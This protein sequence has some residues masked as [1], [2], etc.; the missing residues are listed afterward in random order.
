M[1]RRF[2]K[3][4]N[5]KKVNILTED[6]QNN[7]RVITELLGLSKQE[8]MNKKKQAELEQA[9]REI[10]N[11]DF[12]NVFINIPESK[13]YQDM[14]KLTDENLKKITNDLPTVASLV[15]ELFDVNLT[16]IGMIY[17]YS[18]D[19]NLNPGI[20][21]STWLHALKDEHSTSDKTIMDSNKDCIT[22]FK[23]LIEKRATKDS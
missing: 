13:S 12:S 15:P 3:I 9:Y 7:D 18:P 6:R 1:M 16:K 11:F 22:K 21:P 23:K 17:K 8:K 19:D 2:D 10:D 20:I 4:N 5:I 14:I